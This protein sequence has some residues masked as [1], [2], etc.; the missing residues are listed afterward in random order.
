MVRIVHT[1]AARGTFDKAV[2][3]YVG[4]PT[5]L[6]R[7]VTV[8]CTVSP[9]RSVL[10]LWTPP[11]SGYGANQVVQAQTQA[12]SQMWRTQPP[13]PPMMALLV[14][15]RAVAE[16]E[17][18]DDPAGGLPGNMPTPPGAGGMAGGAAGP[19]WRSGRRIRG[20]WRSSRSCRAAGH[21]RHCCTPTDGGRGAG[22]ASRPGLG[23][24]WSDRPGPD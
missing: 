22:H 12:V 14:E 2:G 20:P 6:T 19:A 18:A 21:A 5:V 3:A 15:A 9:G 10:V 13:T 1:A 4:R 8:P 16:G 11:D 17:G 23:A 7:Q 24:S